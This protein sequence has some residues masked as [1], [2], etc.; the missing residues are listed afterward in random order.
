MAYSSKLL[1]DLKSKVER[2]RREDLRE[3]KATMTETE[4]T[5][6]DLRKAIKEVRNVQTQIK[7]TYR[8]LSIDVKLGGELTRT[9]SELEAEIGQ[10]EKRG[11]TDRESEMRRRIKRRDKDAEERIGSL[12]FRNRKVRSIR[13]RL[14]ALYEALKAFAK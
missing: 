6:R 11:D 12:D 8:R 10:S 4:K 9:L 2:G 1:A 3:L 13:Q 7:R 14:D 5:V